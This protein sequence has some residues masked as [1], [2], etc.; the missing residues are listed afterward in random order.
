MP[1]ILPV[2]DSTECSYNSYVFP[3]ETWTTG[4]KIGPVMDS[5]GRGPIS[6]KYTLTIKALIAVTSA[7]G[8]SST[9]TTF[10]RIRNLLTASGGCFKYVNKGFGTNLILNNPA[11]NNGTKDVAWGPHCRGLEWAPEAG[12]RAGWLTWTVEFQTLDCSNALWQFD[13]MEFAYSVEFAIDQRRMT[14]RTYKGHIRIPNNRISADSNKLNDS[15]DEYYEQVAIPCP[16]GFERQNE[17]RTVSEDKSRLDFTFVDQQLLEAPPPGTLAWKITHR[18]GNAKPVAFSGLWNGVFRGHYKMAIH[19][20]MTDSF[21]HFRGVVRDRITEILNAAFID[22]KGR[23]AVIPYMFD[24]TEDVGEREMDYTFTYAA[25]FKTASLFTAGFW[26]PL[27]DSDFQIWAASMALAYVPRGYTQDVVK[28]TDDIIVNL[29]RTDNPPLA[30]SG[31]ETRRQRGS[32]GDILD[33]ECPDPDNSWLDYELAIV[34]STDDGVV[35][36]KPLPQLPMPDP[37]KPRPSLVDQFENPDGFR[38][39]PPGADGGEAKNPPTR[40]Q[41]R[42]STT[43]YVWLV[44]RAARVC[45][46]VNEPQLVSVGDALAVPCN[47]EGLEYFSFGIVGNCGIPVYV[48]QWCRRYVLIQSPQSPA[49]SPANPNIPPVDFG[50]LGVVQGENEGSGE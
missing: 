49:A 48:A 7:S 2:P 20:P 23:P 14:R 5:P 13:L 34:I 26:R 17:T 47:R 24:M 37:N 38:P 46:E 18:T 33:V 19:K 39:V 44:G 10:E 1:A 36:A 31:G 41:K 25:T 3:V 16:I 30:G 6:N 28:K 22:N 8:L 45:Y 32:L 11:E 42:T 50:N 29:C 15:V 35:V 43:V 21:I 12:N 40:L 4:V 9:D 27:P